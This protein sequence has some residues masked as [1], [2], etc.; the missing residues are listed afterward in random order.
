L[1]F[2]Q[3]AT[4]LSAS[5]WAGENCGMAESDSGCELKGVMPQFEFRAVLAFC[6]QQLD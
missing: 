2:S 5:S 3:S 6:Q 4:A 1:A